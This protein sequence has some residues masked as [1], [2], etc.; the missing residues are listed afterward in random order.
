[1]YARMMIAYA[2]DVCD[3]PGYPG[4]SAQSNGKLKDIV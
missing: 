4:Q 2:H 1:M 3:F